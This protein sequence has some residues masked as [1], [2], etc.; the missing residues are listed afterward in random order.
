MKLGDED[1]CEKFEPTKQLLEKAK[2]ATWEYYKAHSVMLIVQHIVFVL[3]TFVQCISV[4][5]FGSVI[6]LLADVTTAHC[7]Q[8]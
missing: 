8:Y 3:V 4:D 6:R 7:L 2:K 5:L 1:P